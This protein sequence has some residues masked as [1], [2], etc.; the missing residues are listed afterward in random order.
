MRETSTPPHSPTTAAASTAA[1]D[2]S[3]SEALHWQV[4][5]TN[6]NVK[7]D[8]S[9]PAAAAQQTPATAAA[10]DDDVIVRQV[11]TKPAQA[12]ATKPADFDPFAFDFMDDLITR[13][14]S[15]KMN[16]TVEET[17]TAKAPEVTPVAAAVVDHS[18]I[19]WRPPR[20]ERTPRELLPRAHFL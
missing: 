9:D 8:D 13:D 20:T 7:N 19:T 2:V 14:V 5:E 16:I 12:S 1:A 3:Q 6:N 11:V 4:I 17:E 15:A 10:A 18:V